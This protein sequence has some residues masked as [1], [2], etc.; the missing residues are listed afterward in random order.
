MWISDD[1]D[2]VP[3]LMVAETD[4]GDIRMEIVDYTAGTG[5][6]LAVH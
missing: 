1:A 2:R 5:Q 6:N 3:L 4:Y